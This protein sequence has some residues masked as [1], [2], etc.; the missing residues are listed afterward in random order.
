MRKVFALLGVLW[1]WIG[2]SIL[3]LSAISRLTPKVLEVDWATL[4]WY[5][6]TFAGLF[7]V[8]MLHSEGYRGFH[9]QLNPRFIARSAVL[10]RQ[11]SFLRVVFAPLFCIGYFG[12]TRKRQITS[13]AVTTAI[14]LLIVSVSFCPQP[15]RGLI[16]LGVVAGLSL[17]L[18]SLYLRLLST[19]SGKTAFADPEMPLEQIPGGH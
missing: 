8:M 4:S 6:W 2:F 15:W 16:D 14:V 18:L 3:I 10:W 7:L 5:S 1:A 17:G 11:P 9:C 13:F 12:A 19:L